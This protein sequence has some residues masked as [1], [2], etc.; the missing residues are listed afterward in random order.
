MG[1]AVPDTALRSPFDESIQQ[2]PPRFSGHDVLGIH[3]KLQPPRKGEFEKT[4]D[5]EARYAAW[6]ERA[7]MGSLRPSS[8]LAIEVSQVLAPGTI[9]VDYSADSEELNIKLSFERHNVSDQKA[10]W[11]ETFYT[12]K[13]LGPRLATTRMGVKFR[14]TSH[15]GS[16]V[17][18]AMREQLQNVAVSIKSPPEQARLLKTKLTSF[19]IVSLVEP[20]SVYE[21]EAST[22]SLDKPEEWLTRRFGVWATLKSVWIVNRETGEVLQKIDSFPR[23]KY[24]TC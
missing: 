19:A 23:C 15:L 16:S 9:S 24:D 5:F 18:I 8:V 11:L 7:F 3:K 20:F 14:V 4:A 2:L 22:A 13:N 17:G 21:E 6:S 12:S 1:H 10:R